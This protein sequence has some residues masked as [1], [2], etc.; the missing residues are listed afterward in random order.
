MA[1]LKPAAKDFRIFWDNAY[2]I[3]HLYDEEEKQ[4]TILNIIDECKK[5]EMKIWCTNLHQHR[6]LH[7]QVQG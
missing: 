6:K 4:D 1:A 2:A 5:Q 3:H 7:S